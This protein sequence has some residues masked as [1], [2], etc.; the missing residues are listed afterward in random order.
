MHDF[1]VYFGTILVMLF[2]I[3]PVLCTILGCI[4]SKNMKK[5]KKL[6]LGWGWDGAGLRRA[7]NIF[8]PVGDQ[9]APW[10]PTG[11]NI[12]PKILQL[13]NSIAHGSNSR[14]KKKWKSPGNFGKCVVAVRRRGEQAG[15]G[16]GRR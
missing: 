8:V 1:R 9:C 12:N 13:S 2:H 5:L 11:T 14:R 3:S 7:A 6:G 10:S 15:D 16:G 4:T